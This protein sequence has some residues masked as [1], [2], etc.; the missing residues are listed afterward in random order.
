MITAQAP[1]VDSTHEAP[2][3]KAVLV[4][5]A[6]NFDIR[7]ASP[8]AIEWIDLPADRLLGRSIMLSLPPLGQAL[9]L[10]VSAGLSSEPEPLNVVMARPDG[11]PLVVRARRVDADIIIDF[12]GLAGPD[13]G[14]RARGES[15]PPQA[16][17]AT[18]PV[19][20]Q[21][22]MDEMKQ[23]L[24]AL[25]AR[26]PSDE[27]MLR[28]DDPILFWLWQAEAALT[29]VSRRFPEVCVTARKATDT[30]RRPTAP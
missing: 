9:T 24:A 28:G 13:G 6:D 5:A 19:A 11:S 23:D 3:R 27:T 25:R 8:Q 22:R 16:I 15:I 14:G 4:V 26:I 1:A 21:R 2:Q 17:S 10:A 30:Y 18:D 12:T 7:Y 20:L 29:Q